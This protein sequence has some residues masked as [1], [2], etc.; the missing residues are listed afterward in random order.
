MF[1]AALAPF[2]IKW[3]L[4]PICTFSLIHFI[5]SS[6]TDL[7]THTFFKLYRFEKNTN[8]D[9]AIKRAIAWMSLPSCFLIGFMTGWAA[10]SPL[11]GLMVALVTV[12]LAYIFLIK[13]L[14]V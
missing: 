1:A 5:R 8:T 7:T 14:F 4:L 3:L 11:L 2:W 10:F 9:L 6:W 13:E 12:T